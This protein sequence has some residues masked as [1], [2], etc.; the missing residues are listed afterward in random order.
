MILCF[1][2]WAAVYGAMTANKRLS[3]PVFLQFYFIEYPIVDKKD[4]AARALWADF[5]K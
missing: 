1:Y 4:L 3:W 5:I 2:Y